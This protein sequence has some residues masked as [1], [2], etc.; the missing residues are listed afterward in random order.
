MNMLRLPASAITAFVLAT[1]LALAAALV[2]T[3]KLL[4]SADSGSR[5]ATA[6]AE[7]P[8][9][10]NGTGSAALG[11]SDAK[12]KGA[13]FLEAG[14]RSVWFGTYV[15]GDAY[16]GT[17][18]ST[19]FSISESEIAIPII[20]YPSSPGNSL[21]LEI[22]GTQ[23]DVVHSI[24]CQ[25]RNP[26]ESV[27][28]WSIDVS[29]WI[30]HR[31]RLR[32]FDGL[33]SMRGWLGAGPPLSGH[34]WLANASTNFS[35]LLISTLAMIGLLFIPG[36]LLSTC[37]SRF[38]RQAALLPLPGLMMLVLAGLGVWAGLLPRS[39]TA[40]SVVI[41]GL[42]ALTSAGL[43]IRWCRAGSPFGSA[44]R[45]LFLLYGC[46]CLG[47]L[48]FAS[49]PL[50]VPQ[51]F[52]PV[53]KPDGGFVTSG[54]EGASVFL[55][56]RDLFN[57]GRLNSNQT[58]QPNGESLPAFK[59]PLVPLGVVSLLSIFHV[60][61]AQPTMQ[62]AG[63]WPLDSGGWFLGRALGILTNAFV[64]LGGAWLAVLLAPE[65]GRRSMAWLSVAPVVL[66]NADSPTPLLLAAYFS[67]LAVASGLAGGS[68]FLAA[69]FCA[70]AVLSHPTAGMFL[71]PIIGFLMLHAAVP[72]D[73]SSVR[74]VG[75][76]AGYG[77]ALPFLVLLM[78]SPWIMLSFRGSAMTEVLG[79][80]AGDGHGMNRAADP[81]S[82]LMARV[83]NF[84]YTLMPTAAFFSPSSA[85]TPELLMSFPLLWIDGYVRS[86]P[87]NVGCIA[88][89]FCAMVAT[90]R[91]PD[92]LR[93]LWRWLV[94]GA[95]GLMI[96][97]WGSSAEGLGR[98]GL[99]SIAIALIVVTACAPGVQDRVWKW[100]IIATTVEALSLRA[101]AI[102]F[103]RSFRLS[104][105][106]A[107]TLIL[108]TIVALATIAPL[109]WYLWQPRGRPQ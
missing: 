83:S 76:G 12:F 72:R 3:G 58:R 32:L 16:T 69:V 29:A 56:A 21:A 102:C 8:F 37:S 75:V 101:I 103:S 33:T 50:S 85:A 9:G 70:L 17:A 60:N 88:F 66:L 59:S 98:H 2:A 84:W 39:S 30:G 14:D 38:P 106:S 19:E 62:T 55:T 20:G 31:A 34:L 99:E 27:G 10:M 92:A 86:L 57:G 47:S 23:G 18:L 100:L 40:L 82:W 35:G 90:Q 67:M 43:G 80:L 54:H 109:L 61:P 77:L 65:A 44:D 28:I 46:I 74:R 96:V 94:W 53:F 95:L 24:T 15:G 97:L 71:P 22:L 63:E 6:A 42:A 93:P 79:S 64:I 104:A 87:G 107:E 48:A 7:R 49:L 13:V 105:L 108:S 45:S 52:S 91:K 51:S 1:A 5:Q 4:P 68:V 41:L 11:A 36:A 81:G 78:L 73:R 25:A 26:R 89:L